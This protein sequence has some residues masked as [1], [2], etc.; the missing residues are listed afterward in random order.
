MGI[1][2]YNVIANIFFKV[3]C[4]K[5]LL[6]FYIVIWRQKAGIVEETAIARQWRGKHVSTAT[7][8]HASTEE[9]LEVVFSAQSVHS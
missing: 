5:N 6:G 7:N 9:L 8:K 4:W 2:V 3:T 1:Y